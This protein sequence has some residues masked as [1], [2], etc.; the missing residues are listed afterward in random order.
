MGKSIERQRNIIDFTLSSLLRRKGKNISLMIVYTVIVFVLAS[1]MFFTHSIKK[2]AH[3]ILKDAPEMVVQKMIA[4][5]HELIPEGYMEKIGGIRG[6]GSVHGRL[7]GYYYDPTVGA[8]YTLLVP[9]DRKIESGEIIIGNGISRSRLAYEGDIIG[10]RSY[11]GSPMNLAIK[12]ILSYDSE[13]VSSDLVLISRDDFMTLFGMPKGH[14]TDLALSVRN[15]RELPTIAQ[16]ISDLLPDTR[17]IIRNEIERTYD[18]VFDWRGGVMVLILSTAL[19]SFVIFAW[20][21]ASG[22][23]ADEKREI[24]ILKGLGWETSDVIM[25][26][27]WEGVVVSL[28]SFLVGIIL[29][30]IHVFFTHAP[31]FEHTL[32]GW[33]ILYPEFRLT[34]FV[35]AYQ[36]F[37]LFFLTVVPYTVATIIPAWRAAT[38]DPD[39]A[40]RT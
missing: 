38:V 23:S 27:F 18:S 7:W 1:V 40:M 4:G 14:F 21:K 39:S 11:D 33:A 30:Y 8:N 32:K 35:D 24:G 16:K 15:P 29:A 34:P 22:L 36:I 25:I 3:L 9:Q 37:T 13:L 31:L 12:E 28:S 19:L 6:V 26:K 10:F 5:R 2:E 17:P 20:E